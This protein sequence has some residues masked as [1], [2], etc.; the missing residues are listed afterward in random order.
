MAKDVHASLTQRGVK[1]LEVGVAPSLR[2]KG[3]EH[4]K[5]KW[6]TNGQVGWPRR[7][8]KENALKKDTCQ[9][10]VYHTRSVAQEKKGRGKRKKTPGPA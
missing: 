8:R 1:P 2:S 5:E 7:S 6:P 10:G 4:K 3:G 9:C